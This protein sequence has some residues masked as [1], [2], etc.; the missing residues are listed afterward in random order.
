MEKKRGTKSPRNQR[1][2]KQEGAHRVRRKGRHPETDQRGEDGQ[3]ARK[4]VDEATNLREREKRER[5]GSPKRDCRGTAAI[6]QEHE[7]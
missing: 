2:Y 4:I 1:R 3:T 6:P 5:A 7:N